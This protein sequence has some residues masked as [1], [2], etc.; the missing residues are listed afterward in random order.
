MSTEAKTST[1]KDSKFQPKTFEVDWV[2]ARGIVFLAYGVTAL[3]LILRVRKCLRE[4]V[5]KHILAISIAACCVGLTVPIS[6][7][8]T[9]EHLNVFARPRLQSQIVRI[10]WMVSL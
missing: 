4:C 1:V 3:V 5:D 7:Y 9:L 2:I 10:I 8:H 6:I